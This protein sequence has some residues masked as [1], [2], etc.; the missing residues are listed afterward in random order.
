MHLFENQFIKIRLIGRRTEE[1]SKS[2][3]A[4]LKMKAVSFQWF[5]ISGCIQKFP[6]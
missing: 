3:E 1:L 2:N 6:D 4:S 5:P